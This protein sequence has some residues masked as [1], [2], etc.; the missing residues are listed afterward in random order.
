MGGMMDRS[1]VNWYHSLNCD[2]T[3]ISKIV[4]DTYFEV[5]QVI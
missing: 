1:Y 4:N 2:R 5:K 3:L